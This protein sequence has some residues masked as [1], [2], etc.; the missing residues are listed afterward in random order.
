VLP[1]KPGYNL[2]K[3]MASNLCAMLLAKAIPNTIDAAPEL[4][5]APQFAISVQIFVNINDSIE[6]DSA[7]LVK[8]FLVGRNPS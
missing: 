8:K 3:I 2:D 1:Q 7:V 5:F 4:S 6:R